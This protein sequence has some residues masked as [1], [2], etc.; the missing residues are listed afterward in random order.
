MTASPPP[1]WT[2][3]RTPNAFAAVPAGLLGR[4]G[5]HLMRAMNRAEQ[6]EV[7]DLLGPLDGRDV[8]EV[9]HGPGVLLGLLVRR[10]A[11]HVVGV[12]PS[13][14]MR[15][16][17]IRSHAA[18]IADG[19]LEVRPGDAATTGLPDAAADVAVSVNN[20]AIWP[21][22]D[23]GIAELHR[24]LRPGGRLVV[25]WHGGEHPSRAA[26]RMLLPEDRLQRIEDAL[27]S[28]FSQV[29]RTLTRRCTVF[30]AHK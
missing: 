21:D 19:R 10:G 11:R 12:D 29:S 6:G 18:E 8:L 26:K 3:G 9:G 24:V 4:L 13:T 23:A 22:L 7:L 28:R 16:Q 14:E 27:R 2:T 17:A 25:G 1:T 5:G 15:R 30:D 20:V